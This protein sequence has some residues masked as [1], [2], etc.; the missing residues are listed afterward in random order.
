MEGQ[1]FGLATGILGIKNP[2][3]KGE[4]RV[5]GAMRGKTPSMEKS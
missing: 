4:N 5:L 3:R 2:T 1:I